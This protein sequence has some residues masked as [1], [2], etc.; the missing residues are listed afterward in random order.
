MNKI[1][2]QQ[3]YDLIGDIH[4]HAD[5]LEALLLKLG[6][7][8]HGVGYQHPAGRKVIF[9][10]DYI[11]RGPKI[12]R[13][14]HV[15]RGMVDSGDALAVM[16]N[17][18]YNVLAYYTPD[19]KGGW[20]RPRTREKV[21]HHQ[22]TLRQLVEPE[23]AEWEDWKEWF[24]CLPLFLELPGL[25][26]VHASWEDEAMSL[27]RGIRRLDDELLHQMANPQSPLGR[28]K[29]V[30]LNGVELALPEGHFYSDK[31]GFRR[32]FI[33]LRWWEDPRGKT[34]RQMVFPESETVP[35]VI[36]PEEVIR[37]RFDY[38]SEAVPVFN[39]HYWLPDHLERKPL[40]ANIACLD[41]SVAKGGRLT[42]YR[43]DGETELKASNFV[44]MD[45]IPAAS[46][47]F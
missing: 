47:T 23:S 41:Y 35:P 15:V 7:R 8:T 34:Y 3:S 17:H 19:G 28:M 26:A 12:L 4:G 39:G 1:S 21:D 33:R 25:R 43:W 22:E 32:R 5:A 36:I 9:L 16:G 31:Q 27:A 29:N 14:L 13:T 18:E 20:L 30:L 42:A 46:L 11:D 6:Y 2:I 38:P 37:T 44:T 45:E 40:A 10:G 24:R